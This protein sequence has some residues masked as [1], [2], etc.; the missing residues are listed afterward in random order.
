MIAHRLSTVR[1][2]HEILV[3][4]NGAV[5][6]RG[7]H[8]DLLMNPFS[9]YSNMWHK[10]NEAALQQNEKEKMKSADTESDQAKGA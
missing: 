8:D 7:T 10:Q 6:E 5:A 3:L 1:D 4:E 2:A 9:I